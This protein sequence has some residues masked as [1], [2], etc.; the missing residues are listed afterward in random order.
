MISVVIRNKNQDKALE[1]LLRNLTERYMSDIDEIIVID[2]LSIDDSKAVAEKYNANFITIEKFS[3]GGSANFAAKCAKNDIVVIFSAHSFPVSHDF[4]KLI[5]E[6]FKGREDE[7][8]GLRCLHNI[9]DYSGYINNISSIDDYNRAGLIF[10][11]SVFNKRVWE[12]HPFM[13]DITT[14]EDK[15]WTKRVIAEGY[16]IEFVPSIFCYQINRTKAQNFFRFKNETIGSYQL[17]HANYTM[18]KS[19]KGFVHSGFKITS[20]YFTDIFYVFKRFFFM[21]KFLINKPNR[22]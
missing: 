6:K 19:L 17:H 22:F 12:K 5:E 3:Y 11:G 4:F 9:N 1:F 13:S 7:L 18:F 8:A 20:N 2:N 21:I 10:A 16:K 15:E 14:F